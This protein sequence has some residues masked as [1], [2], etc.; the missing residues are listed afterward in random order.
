MC[1]CERERESRTDRVRERESET[2]GQR[3]RE[4]AIQKKRHGGRER[5]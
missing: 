4:R 1:V 3:D 2:E 5:K